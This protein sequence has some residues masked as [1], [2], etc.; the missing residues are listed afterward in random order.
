MSKTL[1][2]GGRAASATLDRLLEREDGRLLIR[3]AAVISKDP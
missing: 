1:T 2:P 3:G